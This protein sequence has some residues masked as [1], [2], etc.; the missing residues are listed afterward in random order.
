MKTNE[1]QQVEKRL[2]GKK[3]F[4]VWLMYLAMIFLWTLLFRIWFTWST[5]DR[6]FH[7]AI[8]FSVG[9]WAMSCIIWLY[10]YQKSIKHR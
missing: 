3:G 8:W 1:L 2:F 4:L 5:L 6:W 9:W 10:Y 7:T